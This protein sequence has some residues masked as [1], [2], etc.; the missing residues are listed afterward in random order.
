MLMFP[1]PLVLSGRG[2]G[3]LRGSFSLARWQQGHVWALAPCLYIAH[4]LVK[5]MPLKMFVE[6]VFLV[7]RFEVRQEKN[8]KLYSIKFSQCPVVVVMFCNS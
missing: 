4:N 3:F 6:C 2:I 5:I 1:G 7:V 8:A